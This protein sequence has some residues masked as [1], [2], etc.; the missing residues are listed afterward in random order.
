MSPQRMLMDPLKA[1]GFRTQRPESPEDLWQPL[2]DRVQYPAAGIAT[3]SFFSVPRGG[4]ATLIVNAAS[5]V[6]V[7]TYRDTNIDNSNVVPTKMFKIVGCSIG[8]AHLHENSQFNP[9]QRDKWREGSWI[10]FR[11]VDKDLIEL[12]II[13]IPEVNPFVVGAVGAGVLLGEAGGGGSNVPMYR[14]GV[15]ITLNPYENFNVEINTDGTVTVPEDMDV[16]LILHA[17]M[18]RPT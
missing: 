7:K 10:K 13:S 6:K 15:P 1:Q 2:Y 12:P 3:L 8:F 4:T 18:R 14:F 5:V 16:Y 11:I 9:S 17:F